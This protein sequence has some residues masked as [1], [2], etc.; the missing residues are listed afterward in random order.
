[1]KVDIHSH[2]TRVSSGKAGTVMA[3]FTDGV[4]LS[5]WDMLSLG[6]CNYAVIGEC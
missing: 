2:R 3:L 5:D 4:R 6:C 1:M